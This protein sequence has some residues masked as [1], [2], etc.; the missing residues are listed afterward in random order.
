MLE[1]YIFV[2]VLFSL[3]ESLCNESN[4]LDNQKMGPM[5]IQPCIKSSFL[6]VML[7]G[8]SVQPSIT[9]GRLA[10]PGTVL[11]YGAKEVTPNR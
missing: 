5:S 3:E 11:P 8:F 7:M 1:R 9:R 6:R 10:V 2:I 4:V